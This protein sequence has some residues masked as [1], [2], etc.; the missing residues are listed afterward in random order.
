MARSYFRKNKTYFIAFNHEIKYNTCRHASE[1]GSVLLVA[2]PSL[3]FRG[4]ILT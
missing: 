4:A 3:C 2:D 1:T